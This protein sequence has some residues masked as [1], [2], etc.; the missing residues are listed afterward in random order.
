[1]SENSDT[2]RVEREAA[3][4]GRTE[5]PS[6]QLADFKPKTPFGHRLWEIRARL[7]ASGERLLGWEDIDLELAERRGGEPERGK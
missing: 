1:M 2:S 5:M 3:E 4:S 6:G 7:V